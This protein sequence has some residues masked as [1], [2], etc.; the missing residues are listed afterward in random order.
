MPHPQMSLS[1]PL[2]RPG[3]LPTWLRVRL[4][5]SPNF[6][7]TAAQLKSLGVNTVCADAK[8]PNHW[9]CWNRGNVAFMIAGNRCTRACLFCAV[10]I[11]RPLPLDPLEPERVAEAVI[12]LN[13]RH[14]V[15]TSVSRDDLPDG[16]AEHFARTILAIRRRKPDVTIEVLVPDFSGRMEALATVINARPQIFNHNVETVRR[17]S[18]KV[19]SRAT[20]ELS[21][22]VLS[23]AAELGAGRLITKSGLM[24]GLGETIDEVIETL[25]DLRAVGCQIV[26]LG[27]Y[28]P[29]SLKAFPVARY[30]SPEEFEALGR[31]ARELGFRYVASGPLVR[32]SYYADLAASEIAQDLNFSNK[33]PTGSSQQCDEMPTTRE[34]QV[35]ADAA[36]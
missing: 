30:V 27:Q 25:K 24:L 20:Y 32:S 34:L 8:C 23:K 19:R 1:S 15:I 5:I 31:T 21:L 9:E 29:P 14:V 18:S 35:P 33:L 28:L 12:R 26:T 10:P 4:P 13:L 22:Y 16:G 36:D 3:P 7:T 2:P 17:L 6:Q 11:A